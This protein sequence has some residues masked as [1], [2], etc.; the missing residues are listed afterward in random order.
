[1]A[2]NCVARV[3]HS[4]TATTPSGAK[5]VV[6]FGLSYYENLSGV[7]TP[8]K[9]IFA[10][11]AQGRIVNITAGLMADNLKGLPIRVWF[12]TVPGDVWED[13]TTNTLDGNS[14]PDHMPLSMAYTLS[15]HTPRRG[16]PHPGRIQIPGVLEQYVDGDEYVPGIVGFLEGPIW[17]QIKS[18]TYTSTNVYSWHQCLVS[19]THSPRPFDVA[20]IVAP[21]V[22]RASAPKTVGVMTRR[23]EKAIPVEFG[24][25]DCRFL[26]ASL[27]VIFHSTDI[28]GIDGFEPPYLKWMGFG[29]WRINLTSLPGYPNPVNF[30]FVCTNGAGAPY[31]LQLTDPS[32]PRWDYTVA[33]TRCNP[34]LWKATG[35]FSSGPWAGKSVTISVSQLYPK[36]T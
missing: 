24:L 16:I 26:P 30:L 9:N 6:G 7:T 14:G 36:Q 13:T 5:K 21:L 10:A 2:I 20:T 12:P 32:T 8:D 4:W 35:T 27:R 15:F 33:S 17:N 22:T 29:D 19:L 23:G 28:P 3:F 11:N 1:M 18:F 25:G 31:H 34:Y